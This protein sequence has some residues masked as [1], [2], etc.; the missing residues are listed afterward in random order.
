MSPSKNFPKQLRPYEKLKSIV[1]VLK[2]LPAQPA[3]PNECVFATA[4][5]L[6]IARMFLF[7]YVPLLA[8]ELPYSVIPSMSKASLPS[9]VSLPVLQAPGSTADTFPAD[10]P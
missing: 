10:T 2:W 7:V 9:I 3:H 6:A 8:P 5:I 1:F 4:E